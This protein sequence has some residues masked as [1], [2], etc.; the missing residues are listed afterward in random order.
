MFAVLLA[1]HSL[2]R[3]VV[4]L[5]G[6]AA[7]GRGIAGW[8]GR[9]WT[10]SDNRTGL[11]FVAMLDLQLLIGLVLYLFLSPTVRAASVNIGAAMREPMLRF[12]LVEHAFGMLAA[13]TLAHI[14]RVRIRK[15]PTDERRHRAAAVYFSIALLLIL[16]SI[17]WP[18]MPAGR[19]LWPLWPW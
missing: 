18:G 10:G 14:G 5:L 16:L 3:W 19:P 17:P 13:V 6:L 12:F 8:K 4:L 7:A 15:A 1:I 9:V 11:W 2:L